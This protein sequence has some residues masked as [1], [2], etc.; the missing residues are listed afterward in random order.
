MP[1]KETTLFAEERKQ[2][3]VEL[4]QQKRKIV[5]PELCSHFGVSASTIRND[6]RDL[7]A[8]GMITRTHGG[9]IINSKSGFEPL[10]LEKE[11]RMPE[12]KRAIARAAARH[13][14]E[15]DIIAIGTGTTTFELVKL[16]GGKRGLTVI[17]NDIF[18]ASYLER[19]DDINVIVVGGTLR[20]KFH[21]LQM[22]PGSDIFGDVNID[23]AFISCNGVHP[24][25][26]ITTPDRALAH[27]VRRMVDASSELYVICDSSKIGAVTFS[28][29]VGIDRVDR[30]ITDDHIEADDEAE[31]RAADVEL[32]IVPCDAPWNDS[33]ATGKG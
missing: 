23:K 24:G 4:V 25:R 17:L 9:A 15:G 18:F 33:P 5:I 12:A 29:I 7:Q 21:Y 22:P 16:L 30:L 20:K 3:I 27:D 8:A 14:E 10:P 2:R 28:R 19:F 11:T 1:E 32:E 6:L 31:L 13:V 26:G